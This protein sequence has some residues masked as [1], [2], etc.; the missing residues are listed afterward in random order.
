MKTASNNSVQQ[1]LLR[2]GS[3]QI[4]LHLIHLHEFDRV[5]SVVRCVQTL[6]FASTSGHF[7]LLRTLL[8]LL[9]RG[10]RA[11]N[12]LWQL[13]RFFNTVLGKALSELLL[14]I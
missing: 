11:L 7:P 8:L 9:E 1:S 2:H 12:Y 5:D 13:D 3:L 4:S 14:S 6:R 10:L